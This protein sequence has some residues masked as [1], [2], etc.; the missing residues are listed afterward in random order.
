MDTLIQDLRY[1]L[2]QLAQ[3]PG[4]AAV[5]VVTLALGIGATTA[6]FSVV[7]AVLLRQMP[8]PSADRLTVLWGARGAQR[9]LLIPIADFNDVRARN[10]SFVDLG[11]VRVQSVN[12]TGGEAPDRLIGSFVTASSLELLGARTA[13]GRLF[14]E[15]ETAIGTGQQVAVLSHGVWQGRFG[16]DPGIVGRTVILNGRPH[17]VIG[18]MAGDFHDAFAPTDVW[19]PI[20]SAPNPAWFAR[21]NANVWGIG[22]L[23]P[24]VSLA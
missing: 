21:G 10:H 2:R 16:A 8:Y 23:K 12:L 15:S 9:P 17:V 18:V 20:T 6:I 11:I 5:A 22:L 3:R 7:N 19:L 1:T 13:A 24:G 4:F 14:T